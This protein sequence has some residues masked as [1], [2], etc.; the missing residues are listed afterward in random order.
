MNCVPPRGP[1]PAMPE[2]RRAPRATTA[3]SAAGR[4]PGR[5]L[6]VSLTCCWLSFSITVDA[7]TPLLDA[8]KIRD[9]ERGAALIAAGTDVNA[10]FADGKT[11]LMVVAKRGMAD[12]VEQLLKAGA[13]VNAANNNGGTALMFAAITGDLRTIQLLLEHGAEMNAVGA[14][15]W[16]ALMV[17]AVKGHAELV[18][19]LLRR[20]ADPDVYGWT[21]SMRAASRNRT[22]TVRVLLEDKRTDIA[23]RDDDGA[24]A[25]HRAAEQGHLEMVELLVGLGA[26]VH[27]LDAR[28][29]SAATR[30]SLADHRA[31][32]RRL[33]R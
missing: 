31:I 7:Q 32:V 30:A 19:I 29:R 9:F 3:S 11:A 8:L 13:K 10:T 16:G 5:L 14:N 21:P 18:A 17:A 25:L 4:R 1:S 6:F 12:L 15:R 24:S 23:H 27:A 26:D 20:G 33:L 2:R 28:G 22:A